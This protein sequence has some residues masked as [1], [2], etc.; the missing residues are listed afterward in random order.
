MPEPV[1]DAALRRLLDAVVRREA[2]V[3]RSRVR[4]LRRSA[5]EEATFAGIVAGLMESAA[6]VFVTTRTGFTCRGRIAALGPDVVVVTGASAGLPVVVLRAD[7]IT[8]VRSTSRGPRTA[9]G[10]Q[11]DVRDLMFAEVLAGLAADRCDV[12]AHVDGEERGL[13]GQLVSAGT[14]VMT[15]RLPRPDAHHVH[16]A[17]MACVAV[18]CR[19]V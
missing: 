19:A 4:W 17:M 11:P 7:A 13:P 5:E 12:V 2:V 16:V 9:A 10:P 6:D 3:D 8:S 15:L 14:D 18:A 1:D